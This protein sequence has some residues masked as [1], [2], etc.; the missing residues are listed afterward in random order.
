MVAA[1]PTYTTLISMNEGGRDEEMK[2]R[3]SL[4]SSTSFDLDPVPQLAFKYD[5]NKQPQE[6]KSLGPGYEPGK[7][8][9]ICSKGKEARDHTG[10]T[11]RIWHLLSSLVN[12]LNA[13]Y[14]DILITSTD[15]GINVFECL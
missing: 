3:L 7:F 14:T 5:S 10:K 6:E 8:D 11:I 13:L 9:V 2:T 1:V 4:V 15:Q 12:H